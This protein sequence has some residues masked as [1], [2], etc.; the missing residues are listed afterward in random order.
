MVNV[1]VTVKFLV[2]KIFENAGS[3]HTNQSE[4]GRSLFINTL[5]S[6]PPP[7]QREC[8]E[9]QLTGNCEEYPSCRLVFNFHL[10]QV[11]AELLHQFDMFWLEF[12]RKEAQFLLWDMPAENH[13][14]CIQPWK[15]RTYC[16]EYNYH[17]TL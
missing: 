17:D 10:A 6:L 16:I 13:C 9:S 7:P 1:H 15:T 5:N 3:T 2:W 8:S 14:S 11:C 12:Q 4:C